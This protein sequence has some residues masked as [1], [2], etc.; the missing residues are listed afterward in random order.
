MFWIPNWSVSVIWQHT[1]NSGHIFDRDMYSRYY[2]H[3]WH[4]GKYLGIIR[5]I[6]VDCSPFNSFPVCSNSPVTDKGFFA[7]YI[8]RRVVYKSRQPAKFA[9][10]SVRFRRLLS[11]FEESRHVEEMMFM[12]S[13]LLGLNTNK[14]LQCLSFLKTHKRLLTQGQFKNVMLETFVLKKSCCGGGKVGTIW[15]VVRHIG[16]RYL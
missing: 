7:A 12:R 2:I 4:K 9:G 5:S 10:F 11:L 14:N 1:G 15:F 6:F 3:N 13:K 16:F 8:R